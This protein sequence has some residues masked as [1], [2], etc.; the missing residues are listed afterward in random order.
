MQSMVLS[1][2]K[3]KNSICES[4]GSKSY[5]IFFQY[6]KKFRFFVSFGVDSSIKQQG[7]MLQHHMQ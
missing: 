1:T 7:V 3:K 6:F 4:Y 2:L 5:N